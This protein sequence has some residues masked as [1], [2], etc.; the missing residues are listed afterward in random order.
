MALELAS[1]L[2]HING[3]HSFITDIATSITLDSIPNEIARDDYGLLSID[4]TFG[5]IVIDIGAH[6]GI[7]SIYLAKRFPFLTIL[8]FEPTPWNFENLRQNLAVNGIGNVHAHNLAVTGDGRPLKMAVHPLNTGGASGFLTD[9]SQ[10]RHDVFV[11]KATT[12]DAIVAD[13]GISRVRLLKMDCE[14]AE[15]EIIKATKVLDRVEFF[16]GEF[17]TNRNL[18]KKGHTIDATTA[19]L[20]KAVDPSRVRITRCNMVE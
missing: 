6:V 15:H 19:L 9:T 1:R 18:A 13:H 8:A 12:L 20:T 7:T 17:H 4:F 5:D 10:V 3:I 16:A 11:A 14:G 2:I